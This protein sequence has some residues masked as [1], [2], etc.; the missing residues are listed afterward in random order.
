MMWIRPFSILAIITLTILNPTNA[1]F[2]QVHEK[3]MNRSTVSRTNDSLRLPAH[4]RPINYLRAKYILNAFYLKANM[5]S[6]VYSLFEAL[7]NRLIAWIDENVAKGGFSMNA[8]QEIMTLCRR[9]AEE[10]QQQQDYQERDGAVGNIKK[11]PIEMIA[12]VPAIVATLAIPQRAEIIRQL[13]TIAPQ[14]QDLVNQ[15]ALYVRMFAGKPWKPLKDKNFKKSKNDKPMARAI[16]RLIDMAADEGD[17]GCVL[18][19]NVDKVDQVR[20][21]LSAGLRAAMNFK[22]CVKLTQPPAIID[23]FARKASMIGVPKVMMEAGR[24]LSALRFEVFQYA[25]MIPKSSKHLLKLV[26]RAVNEKR[27]LQNIARQV[28]EA[29]GKADKKSKLMAPIVLA[30]LA[31]VSSLKS[32]MDLAQLVMP[33]AP[34]TFRL[35]TSVMFASLQSG[36]DYFK[37]AEQI[38]HA[39][40]MYPASK[41]GQG[42]HSAMIARNMGVFYRQVERAGKLS[43]AEKDYSL[44]ISSAMRK[45][46]KALAWHKSKV[47]IK[48]DP[49]MDCLAQLSR[50]FHDLKPSDTRTSVVDFWHALN[51]Y[52]VPAS[53]PFVNAK[54][55]DHNKVFAG[56]LIDRLSEFKQTMTAQRYGRVILWLLLNGYV[57]LE[58]SDKLSRQDLIVAYEVGKLRL[59][60]DA[61]KQCSLEN[62]SPE[63]LFVLSLLNMEGKQ[64]KVELLNV[65]LKRRDVVAMLRSR[66]K[67]PSLNRTNPSAHSFARSM[68]IIAKEVV[69]KKIKS[70]E[71]LPKVIKDV[72]EYTKGKSQIDYLFATSLLLK[73]KIEQDLEVRLGKHIRPALLALALHADR[74]VR[75]L[76]LT[77]M[78]M[79]CPIEQVLGKRD[80]GFVNPSDIRLYFDSMYTDQ[81]E[82]YE[83]GQPFKFELSDDFDDDS[84]Q[85]V[86]LMKKE[87]LRNGREF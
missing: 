87:I 23:E 22:K 41:W 68:A 21:G 46:F 59:L 17:V 40:H 7:L 44:I 16:N 5:H 81:L 56:M 77:C 74:N 58:D 35:V 84:S 50:S 71:E 48:D 18:T 26:T 67:K 52:T 12:V 86:R 32:V 61:R 82:D 27:D 28:K 66:I 37:L 8:M 54:V 65:L 3:T 15:F 64:D 75:S 2:L 51:R 10:L 38:D 42:G 6:E 36:D 4:P 9:V 45:G 53:I 78:A 57:K 80:L 79:E 13:A 85:F 72:L 14:H 30:P 11:Q 25:S 62:N 60:C 39:Q 63:L 29:V 47:P 20:R 70:D 34:N 43:H 73:D 83:R 1:K 49:V 69:E 33:E 55:I 76:L 31:L 19:A 24:P